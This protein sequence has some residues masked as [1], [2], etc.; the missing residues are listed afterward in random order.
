MVSDIFRNSVIVAAHPD[1]E[2]LWFSS[3][4]N[5]VDHV[6]L[7][8]LSEMINPEFGERRQQALS[9]IQS[10]I[11]F[12]Q[13]LSCL[14]VVSL[15]VTKPGSYLSPKFCQ[16]GLELKNRYGE[17]DKFNSKYKE[18]YFKL[19]NKLAT[20]LVGYQNVVTHNPWGEYGHV[21]HV[22]VYRAVKE[23]QESMGFD[24]WYSNYCSTR[25]IGLITPM[26]NATKA[27]TFGTNFNITEAAMNAYKETDC[28]TW[29]KGWCWAKEET[30]FKE[31]KSGTGNLAIGEM[32]SLNLVVMP[33][34]ELH[35][36]SPRSILGK[37]T[38]KVSKLF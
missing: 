18:N 38:N 16:Y 28:W 13:K 37:L 31:S 23:L 12:G 14:E 30:F 36:D 15:G 20:A 35:A 11:Q 8:Y 19:R 33:A 10:K 2:I 27:V 34:Q 3:L 32:L 21:E 26:L 6:L 1:D 24:I 25:T 7:C 5:E 17:L 22:Q 29:Y 4:L 9:K